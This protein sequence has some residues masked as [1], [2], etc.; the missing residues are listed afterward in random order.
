MRMTTTIGMEMGLR[1]LVIARMR[2][3]CTVDGGGA[4]GETR[5]GGVMKVA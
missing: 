3:W 5:R 2:G 1:A 4:D